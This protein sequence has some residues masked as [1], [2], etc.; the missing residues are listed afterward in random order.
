VIGSGIVV[1]LLP[2]GQQSIFTKYESH[3]AAFSASFMVS[4]C[5]PVSTNP[6]DCGKRSVPVAN[7][8][9]TNTAIA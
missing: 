9:S 8:D 5:G 3:F 7:Q 6:R 2:E 1:Y 4:L